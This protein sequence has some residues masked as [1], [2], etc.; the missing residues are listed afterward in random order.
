MLSPSSLCVI[1][2]TANAHN[3]HAF[4]S[5]IHDA[6]VFGLQLALIVPNKHGGSFQKARY[7]LAVTLPI[8]YSLFRIVPLK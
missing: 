7:A 6:F 8:S 1:L 2:I 3:P 5:D 4:A